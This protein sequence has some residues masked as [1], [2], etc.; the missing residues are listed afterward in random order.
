MGA[1]NGLEVVGI[2]NL[3]VIFQK[4]LDQEYIVAAGYVPIVFIGLAAHK[5]GPIEQHIGGVTHARFFAV[6]VIG[7]ECHERIVLD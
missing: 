1:N 4:G 2:N 3:F 5:C 6:G 7:A